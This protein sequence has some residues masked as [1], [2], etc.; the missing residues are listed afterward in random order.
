MINDSEQ[1]RNST[2]VAFALLSSWNDVRLD[3]YEKTS[4]NS[5][6]LNAFGRSCADE[7]NIT[8]SVHAAKT[9][10]KVIG[11]CTHNP[12]DSGSM[13]STAYKPAGTPR[14]TAYAIHVR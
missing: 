12:I 3:F 6:R 13:K 1:H 9:F 4:T 2:I 8:R 14:E 5:A 11:I 10:A 7:K